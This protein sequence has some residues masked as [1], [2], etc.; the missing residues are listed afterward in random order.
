MVAD[1]ARREEV[2]TD[3]QFKA[4]MALVLDIMNRSVDL[5]D[6]KRAIGKLAG[7]LSED[8]DG[9]NRTED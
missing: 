7:E 2:M 5:D 9:A 1:T 3:F 6:A 8:A 4:L